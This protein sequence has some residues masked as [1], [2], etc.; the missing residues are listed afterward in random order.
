MSEA[1]AKPNAEPIEPNTYEPPT[2]TIAGEPYRLR[3]LDVR[4]VFAVS[5]ILGRGVS[6]LADVDKVT[7]GVIVQVLIS[8]MAHQ[9]Q[10]TLK[11][12][13]SL[14][15]VQPAEL[16]DPDRFPMDSIV[17]IFM[18]VAEHQDLAGFFAAVERLQDKLPEMQTRSGARSS[19]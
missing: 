4:D 6:V 8:S 16:T 14:I 11:L 3:R 12:M 10:E 2:I 7:P 5:R 1:S 19:S 13:A 15:G 9:E 18:A 17:T